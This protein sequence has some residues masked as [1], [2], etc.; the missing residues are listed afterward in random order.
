MNDISL[1]LRDF[2]HTC[3]F[4]SQ[5][6]SYYRL[7]SLG[8]KRPLTEDDLYE[9]HPTIQ[10]QTVVPE[11]EKYWEQEK[12]KLPSKQQQQQQQ[13]SKTCESSIKKDMVNDDKKSQKDA[14]I[15]KPDNEKKESEE[16]DNKPG[17]SVVKVLLKTFWVDYIICILWNF[18]ILFLNFC[19]PVLLR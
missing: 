17:V 13:Q 18:F 6:Q 8:Y 12:L 2:V 1:A 10:S 14:T 4:N 11:F 7:I 15:G 3:N 19:N 9:L 16:E 5:F